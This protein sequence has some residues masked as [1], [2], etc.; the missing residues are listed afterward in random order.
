MGL[1]QVIWWSGNLL[2][3]CIL[4]RAGKERL[5][6]KYPYFFG[7]VA[8]VFGSTMVRLYL[9]PAVPEPPAERLY[10]EAYWITQFVSVVAG[11]GVTWEI[12]SQILA[13]YR[14]VRKMART[15]VGALLAILMA[16]AVV[17][18][19]GNPIH[20]L[21]PTTVEVERNLRVV[22]ALLLLAMLGLVVHY[23]IPIGRNIR[24]MLAGYAFFIGCAIV[25]LSLRS[26]LGKGF[27]VA[28]SLVQRL[29]YGAT[30]V[31]WCIGM[32]SYAR[33]PAPDNSLESDYDR[34]SR[35]TIKALGQLRAHVMES[36]RL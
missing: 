32:W 12:Y 29:S 20:L 36:W 23:A 14:G 6:S 16:Q 21:M 22:Q 26:L 13:P 2:L 15:I 1:N 24:S 8:C 31:V 10:G 35:N 27:D 3:A 4:V 7:Y 5:F 11:F 30:L 9:Q 25:A 34:V 19:W 18:L 28:E 17:Q 33:N